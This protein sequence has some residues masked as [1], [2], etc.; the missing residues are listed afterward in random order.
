MKNEIL[1]RLLVTLG[2][3]GGLYLLIWVLMKV[4]GA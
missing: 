1:S 3:A 4:G 2:F